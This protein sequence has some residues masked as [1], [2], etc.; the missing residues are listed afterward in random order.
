MSWE[1][2]FR[3]RT[4]KEAIVF[5][6][7]LLAYDPNVRP[8]PMVA[9]ADPYFDELRDAKTRLPNGMAMPELFNFNKGTFVMRNLYRGV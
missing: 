3:T 2:V 8:H 5:V 9:L 1:K 4:P 6:A 7:K